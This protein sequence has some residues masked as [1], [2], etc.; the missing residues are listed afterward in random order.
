M[1][2]NKTTSIQEQAIKLHRKIS[3]HII[4][5]P[6]IIFLAWCLVVATPIIVC[7]FVKKPSYNELKWIMFIVSSIT[8]VHALQIIWL[9][10]KYLFFFKRLI[11]LFG[12]NEENIKIVFKTI[13]WPSLDI[14]KDELKIWLKTP[15]ITIWFFIPPIGYICAMIW[16]IFEIPVLHWGKDKPYFKLKKSIR[17]EIN[18]IEKIEK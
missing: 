18:S 1:K 17:E 6:I 15:K 12:T 16:M 3:W 14:E 5:M 2:T 7:V 9:C 8:F 10:F 4:R 13:H 11:K